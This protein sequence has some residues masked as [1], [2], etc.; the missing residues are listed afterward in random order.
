MA[1]EKVVTPNFIGGGFP[2]VRYWV[3]TFANEGEEALADYIA[4][5]RL[6]YAEARKAKDEAEMAGYVKAGVYAKAV[7]A[8]HF[9][10]AV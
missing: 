5:L 9:G 1:R 7:Y 10:A 2:V 8:K 4:G 3:A 6:G